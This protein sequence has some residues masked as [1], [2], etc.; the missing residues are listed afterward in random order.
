MIYNQIVTWTA[1]AILAMFTSVLPHKWRPYYKGRISNSSLYSRG[2]PI[3][4]YLW[5]AVSPEPLRVLS[6]LQAHSRRETKTHVTILCCNYSWE[7]S[8]TFI[9]NP[10]NGVVHNLLKRWWGAVSSNEWTNLDSFLCFE[11]LR[12][13]ALHNFTDWVNNMVCRW[14]GPIWAAKHPTALKSMI[15]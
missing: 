4:V 10:F 7:N 9:L 5:T 2:D 12:L 13:G 15:F 1:F 11:K 8:G 3:T 6:R 14:S